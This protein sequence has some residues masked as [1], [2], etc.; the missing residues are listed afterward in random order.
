[1]QTPD[2]LDATTNWPRWGTCE[3]NMKKLKISGLKNNFLKGDGSR[4]GQGGLL[5]GARHHRHRPRHQCHPG[6]PDQ[7]EQR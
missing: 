6:H 3:K 7:V 5:E 4:V 1:M 2:L